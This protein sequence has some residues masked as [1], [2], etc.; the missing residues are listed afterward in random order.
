MRMAHSPLDLGGAHL[1]PMS[2]GLP[3][4][5]FRLSR[6]GAGWGRF[7][8]R[9]LAL[10]TLVL[11]FSI[12]DA[13]LT[14]LLLDRSCEEA[15]P[16]LESALMAGGSSAFLSVK[17]L[18]TSAGLPILVAF[19]DRRLFRSP[20]RVGHLLVAVVALYVLLTG[21]QVSLFC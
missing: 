1:D 6:T 14:M 20:I 18:L 21:Y 5:S 13:V 15:N 10:S 12:N 8:W 19:K 4:L 2:D 11:A 3:H 9:W 16:L 17:Y 7:H